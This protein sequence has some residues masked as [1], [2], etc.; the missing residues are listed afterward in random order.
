MSVA[1]ITVA[2]AACYGGRELSKLAE[3]YKKLV[4]FHKF[5]KRI[6][7]WQKALNQPVEP[8]HTWEQEEE[9]AQD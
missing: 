3:D 8:I 2:A 5:L 4:S 1:I 9:D 7:E 6:R